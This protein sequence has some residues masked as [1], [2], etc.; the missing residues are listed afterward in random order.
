MALDVPTPRLLL[1]IRSVKQG[2]HLAQ[3]ARH[4]IQGDFSA[5]KLRDAQQLWGGAQT[6]F[7]SLKHMGETHED[8]VGEEHFMEDWKSEHKRVF[9][10]SGCKDDQTSADANIAGGH[11]GAMSWAF[12]EV[13]KQSSQLS[14]LDILRNT[15]GR[16]LSLF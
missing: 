11:V 6:F 7:H 13:M 4:L 14:Y 3:A 12:L 15:R 16:S 9:M 10:Y 8:G 1:T 2:M 5:Q